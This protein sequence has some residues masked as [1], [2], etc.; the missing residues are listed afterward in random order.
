MTTEDGDRTYAQV[1]MHR[2]HE[3]EAEELLAD[4]RDYL[5]AGM[6]TATTQQERDRYRADFE[7][8]FGMVPDED[9]EMAS[10]RRARLQERGVA[11]SARMEDAVSYFERRWPVPDR[12]SQ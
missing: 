1:A 9:D 8:W 12:D 6:H 7:H 11:H 10:S 3:L 4:V 2:L 5:L